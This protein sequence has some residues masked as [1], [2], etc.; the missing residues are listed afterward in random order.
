MILHI[1]KKSWLDKK[2]E[3]L[4]IFFSCLK[5]AEFLH[6]NR[7]A[8]SWIDYRRDRP[9]V[10]FAVELPVRQIYILRNQENEQTPPPTLSR[11]HS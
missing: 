7:N 10:N 3:A 9:G 8:K 1:W 11:N 2:M 5:Y 6:Y 4:L